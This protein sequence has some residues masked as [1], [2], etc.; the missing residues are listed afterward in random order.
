MSSEIRQLEFLLEYPNENLE[1][2]Y[3]NWLDL[4]TREGQAD[5]AKAIIALANHG[6]G[7]V[8]VGFRDIDSVLTPDV[9]RPVDLSQYSQD[10]INGIIRRYADPVFHCEC[11]EIEHPTSGLL[12]P[13]ILVPG[14]HKTPIRTRRGGPNNQYFNQNVY[15]I[16]RP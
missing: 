15:L 7:N 4:S 9:P 6:G 14:G 10:R 5:I 11:R 16:R 8:I 12:Y 1:R 3:K 2:E 13:I